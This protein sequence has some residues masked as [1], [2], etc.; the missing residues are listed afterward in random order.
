LCKKKRITRSAFDDIDW[1]AMATAMDLFPPLYR[2]WVS[3]HVSGFFGIGTMMLNWKYWEHSPC[4]CCHYEREDK[5]HLL[6]CP[7]ADCATTWQNSLL[8]LEA[9][10]LETDM[11]PAISDCL[12][13]TLA[14]RNLTQLF[15]AF[16]MPTA[17]RAAQAQDRIGWLHTTEGKISKQWWRIQTAHYLTIN[18]RRSPTK[19][20]AGLITNLLSV[21]HS[22][23][24]HRCAVAH[25]RDA[26]GLKLKE[27]RD[28][29]AA[30]T[31]LALGVDGLH[32]RD[33][34]Y[35]TRG[36][37]RILAL[38]AANKLQKGLVERYLHCTRN[39]SGQ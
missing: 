34:H 3:K 4:P 1:E 26:Q 2:L 33:R 28:L 22:Q 29:M 32:A 36:Q 20:A 31:A 11:A 5:L 24:L 16:C 21:T 23:W 30:I 9:W 10:M 15:T 35:I 37:D 18:S 38:P 7:H 12:L 39:I 17:L 19:W 25:E 6:T 14:T 8:G 13:Q 27:G